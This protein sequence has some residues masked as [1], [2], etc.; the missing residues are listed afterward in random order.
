MYDYN[1]IRSNQL[2]MP[3][4]TAR[5]RLIKSIL[6]N[7]LQRHGEDVCFKCS[8][9]IE[10]IEELTIEHKQPWL[11]V[12]SELFWDL[13][14]IAFSHPAPCNSVDRPVWKFKKDYAEHNKHLRKT[15]PV[16]TAWCSGCKEFL[17]FEKF[18]KDA[19]EWDHIYYK[20]KECRART[21]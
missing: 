10:K 4:A 2:G 20:C 11:H 21:R 18:S 14:N 1:K 8:K 19:R 13:D 3:M 12:S 17:P 16:G 6:F 15:G 7:M 5:A 9:K